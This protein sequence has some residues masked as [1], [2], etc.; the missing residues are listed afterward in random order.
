[1]RRKRPSSGFCPSTHSALDIRTLT[2]SLGLLRGRRID[3]ASHLRDLVRGK[4]PALR[5]LA[6]HLLVWCAIDAVDL[7]VR[8]VAVDPLDLRP[9]VAKHVA[10][11]LR[12]GL[13]VGRVELP[14][15]GH[16]AFDH[17]FGHATPPT[18]RF[19][20]C[21]LTSLQSLPRRCLSSDTSQ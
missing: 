20:R 2:E 14:N 21:L 16:F 6:D 3:H 11:G 15:A 9:E 8:N 5:V 1:M 12:R 4:A 13:E 7:I 17:I 10:R 19:E 18:S